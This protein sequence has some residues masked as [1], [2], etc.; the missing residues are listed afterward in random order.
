MIRHCV[1]GGDETFD[2]A[3]DD[4]CDDDRDDDHDDDRDDEGGDLGADDD[5]DDHRVRDLDPDA[6][7]RLDCAVAV[8]AWS[9]SGREHVSDARVDAFFTNLMPRMRQDLQQMEC[10]RDARHIDRIIDESLGKPPPVHHTATIC[11]GCGYDPLISYDDF[12]FETESCPE[13]S[14]PRKYVKHWIP[15]SCHLYHMASIIKGITED[16]EMAA[17]LLD[18]LNGVQPESSSLRSERYLFYR[19]LLGDDRNIIFCLHYDGFAPFR[20]RKDMYSMG[21]LLLQPKVV[22]QPL[23]S[24]RSML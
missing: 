22:L 1:G 14:G 10:M 7:A 17:A 11:A 2:D 18:H 21:Y 4:D 12:D 3:Y 24:L 8:K 13:C 15:F 6:R 9:S 19:R 23:T 5:D 20:T 16:P